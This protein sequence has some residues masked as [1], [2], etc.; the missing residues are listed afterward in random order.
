[1]EPVPLHW[2]GG[3]LTLDHR[4]VLRLFLSYVPLPQA[5]ISCVSVL[6]I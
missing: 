3:V 1:M 5:R 4:E 2:K 6:R